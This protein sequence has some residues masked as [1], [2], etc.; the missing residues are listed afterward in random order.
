[1]ADSVMTMSCPHT[2]GSS[3][4]RAVAAAMRLMRGASGQRVRVMPQTA[5][6]TTA[7]ATTFKPCSTPAGTTSA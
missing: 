2:E 3:K 4:T 1:M 6:A 5:W 7:T